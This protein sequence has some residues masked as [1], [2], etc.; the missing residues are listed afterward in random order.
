[1]G[2][3]IVYCFGA[4]I[5][6]CLGIVWSVSCVVSEWYGVVC[7]SYCELCTVYI[8]RTVYVYCVY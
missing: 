3:G 7:V 8:V 2:A 6:Y 1:M 4:G 5:L